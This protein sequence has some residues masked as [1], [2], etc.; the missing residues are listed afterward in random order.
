MGASTASHTSECDVK[1]AAD[2]RAILEL[3]IG[4]SFHVQIVVVKIGARDDVPGASKGGRL[5]VLPFCNG[6]VYSVPH[7]GM[8][9]GFEPG[10]KGLSRALLGPGRRITI[11][12]FQL[13][14]KQHGF[15]RFQII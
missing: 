3:D 1:L 7:L 6:S 10:I 15:E 13:C 4:G 12:G 11:P 2:L 14:L 9:F 5:S 8:C